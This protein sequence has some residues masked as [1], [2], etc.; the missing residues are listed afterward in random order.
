MTHSLPRRWDVQENSIC[1]MAHTKAAS[2]HV[3][4]AHRHPAA[5]SMLLELLPSLLCPLLVELHCVQVACGRDGADDGVGHGAAASAWRDRTDV[6]QDCWGHSRNS[7]TL[8]LERPTQ[9]PRGQTIRLLMSITPRAACQVPAAQG[10]VSWGCTGAG[11]G[12]ELGFI[13]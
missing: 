9:N 6:K 12:R 4:V 5:H 7:S 13:S 10:L 1:H 3:L 8:T 2:A 11:W